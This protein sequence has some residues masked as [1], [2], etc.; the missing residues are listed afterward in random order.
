MAATLN[1]NSGPFLLLKASKR[2]PSNIFA[3]SGIAEQNKIIMLEAA[4]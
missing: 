3:K 1:M 4:T 2:K